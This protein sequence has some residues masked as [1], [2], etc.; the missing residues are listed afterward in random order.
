MVAKLQTEKLCKNFGDLEA[1]KNIDMAV[2]RGEFI[3]IVGPSGCGK[4]TLLRHLAALE[5]SDAGELRFDGQLAGSRLS[6]DVRLMYQDA[7][8]LPW[9]RVLDNV[10]LGL[11]GPQAREQAL[12]AL[13]AV[14][15]AERAHDWPWVLSG[16]QRQRVAL[17]A[18]GP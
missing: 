12:A 2:E 7:R 13:A 14:G 16:G 8:L 9:K 6:P 11:S 10:A 15:L 1:V 17:W 4:S 18:S 3:A 5:A